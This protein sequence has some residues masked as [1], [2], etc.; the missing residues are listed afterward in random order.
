MRPKALDI[1][2]YTEGLPF[3]GDTLRRQALGGSETAFIHVARQLVRL[4]HKVTAYCLCTKEGVY[5]G[6]V[7]RDVAKLAELADGG[8]DLFICSRYFSV[9]SGDVR[10][11]LSFLWM[12][13]LL[14]AGDAPALSSLLPKIDA[15]YCLSDY[16]RRGVR[17]TLPEAGPKLRKLMNGIDPALVAEA[18]RGVRG[19]R[20]KIMF[21]SRPKR[22]LA[23]ALDAYEKLADKSLEFLICSYYCS[24]DGEAEPL[25]ESFRPRLD[26]LVERGFPV[27]V[28][29]LAQG[30]LYRHIAES[31][32]VVYPT[33]CEEVFCISAVEAQ[34]CGTVFLTT[35]DFALRET[36]GYERVAPGDAAGFYERLRAILSD[37]ELRRE[38]ERRGREHVAPYTWQNV[39]RMLAG[40]AIADLSRGDDVAALSR[41]RVADFD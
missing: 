31:K 1:V 33:D 35:D 20:H 38:L 21:T 36:V 39:A 22:G 6:V 25:W 5:D 13:E 32:A 14:A 40:D 18:A 27:S 34:A 16:H 12:H 9:F 28:G 23:R 2:L 8:C 10:A 15:V 29:S 19:K 11:R 26:G 30:E 37:D 17:R 3:A 41:P 7:Y 4:G 24:T